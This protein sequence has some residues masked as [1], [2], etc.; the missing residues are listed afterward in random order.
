MV[1]VPNRLRQLRRASPRSAMHQRKVLDD[2]EWAGW[3][4]WPI[5]EIW[6]QIGAEGWFNPAFQKFINTEIA[7]GNR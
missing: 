1:R 2:N 5:S 3:L 4:Q 6:K 7:T